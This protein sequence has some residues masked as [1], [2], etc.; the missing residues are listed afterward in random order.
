MIPSRFLLS[1]LFSVSVL[2][3]CLG[4]LTQDSF[5][6]GTPT[7]TLLA[8]SKRNHTLAIVDPVSLKILATVPVGSDPHEVIA[9]SDGKTA[10]VS[11]YGGGS[12]HELDAI[13]LVGQ[14]PLATIDTKPF[15]GPH[16]LFFAGGK[17]W[18]SVEGTKTIARFD[19]ETGKFDWCLGT[20]QDRTHMVYV[21]PDLKHIYTTNV[22]S[23]TVSI[24][25]D[26]MMQPPRNMPAGNPP[27]GNAPPGNAPP[28]G[29]GPR[30]QWVLNIVPVSRGAEGFDVSPDGRELWTAASE[31][32]FIY[33]INLADQKVVEKIDAKVNGANRLKFTP[34]G[35]KVLIS[36]LRNGDLTV[37]D[38]STRREL[39]KVN[40]GHGA[41]GILMDPSLPRA[42]VACSPDNYIA[43]VDLNNL[44]VTGHVDVGG[45]PD[46]LAWAVRP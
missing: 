11:I 1:R 42:F 21:A 44:T 39:K 24:I 6:Q 2:L 41:A 23:G 17:L 5:G 43:I 36:S 22:A 15:F 19:P 13:D 28:P 33:V 20:G 10:W 12:L 18:V 8:L 9:S 35:K 27:P 31:D 32:G 38:A 14:K 7:Q 29:F 3:T 34:D 25:T 16:G 40:I 37:Y 26:S 4:W 45:E 46:G 30:Q